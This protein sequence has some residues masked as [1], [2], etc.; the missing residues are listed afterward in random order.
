MKKR[1]AVILLLV[2][3]LNGPAV[4]GITIHY[5][6]KLASTNALTNVLDAA[7]NFATQ[8][9]WKWVAVQTNRVEMTRFFHEKEQKYI[10]PLTGVVLFPHEMCEPLHIEFGSDLVMQDFVK[11]QF[12]GVEVHIAV[13]EFLRRVK[14]LCQE[15]N[16][17]DDSEYWETNDRPMLESHINTVNKLVTQMKKEKPSSRGPLKLKDGRIVDIIQ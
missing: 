6:G 16:V 8:H 1:P 4:A 9:G 5:E 13:V 11:T 12:A 2:L 10:G 17:F 7:T 3:V 14:P 15:L